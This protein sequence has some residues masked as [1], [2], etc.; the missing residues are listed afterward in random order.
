MTPR[1]KLLKSTMRVFDRYLDLE[2]QLSTALKRRK[3]ES[4]FRKLTVCSENGVDFSSND[5]L[6]LRQLAWV[7]DRLLKAISG[8]KYIGS[9]GSRLLDGNSTEYEALERDLAEFYA[10]DSALLFNS[11]YDANTAVLGTIPQTNDIIIYDELVHA[12][13]HNGMK[14][15]R[16]SSRMPFKHN[17]VADAVAVVTRAASSRPP[18][19]NIFVALETVYSMDGDQA[20]LVELIRELS[21]IPRTYLIVDEA[22]STGIL[23][24]QGRGLC[25]Q[26]GIERQVAIRI[27]T[28]GKA[29]SCNGGMLLLVLLAA[30]ILTSA[31]VLASETIRSYLVN[32]GRPLIYS[33]AM[34]FPAL[35]AIRVSHDF[36]LSEHYPHVRTKQAFLFFFFFYFFFQSI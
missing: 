5:Y 28:F 7:K 11:G 15:S 25:H 19:A 24:D 20:P 14:L 23:G 29:L 22:H 32:Y 26:L 36:L 35:A 27:H 30:G 2:H 21:T 33:T 9:G 8:A 34:S 4:K 12:S 10:A 1:R 13:M 18:D 3:N 16:A 31:V 17:S 6:S